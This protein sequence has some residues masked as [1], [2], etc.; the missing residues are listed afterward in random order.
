MN[1]QYI[2]RLVP[3]GTYDWNRLIRPHELTAK[4]NRFG[5]ETTEIVGFGFN[6]L[7]RRF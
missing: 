1:L 5:V 6:P 2:L 4:L 7:G 3:R